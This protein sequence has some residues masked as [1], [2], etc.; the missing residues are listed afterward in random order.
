MIH[1]H[2]LQIACTSDSRGFI[3]DHSLTVQI[4]SEQRV[5]HKAH[6]KKDALLGLRIFCNTL[7]ML[8]CATKAASTHAV[9]G[10]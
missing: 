1:V 3:G 8:H 5:T 4:G 6:A 7:G 2:Q 9:I 10:T